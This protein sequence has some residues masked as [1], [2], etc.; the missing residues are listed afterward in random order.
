MRPDD[1]GV[2]IL[3]GGAA[4]RL[5][6][7]LEIRG[8]DG[9]PLLRAVYENVRHAGPVVVAA[10][11]SLSRGLDNALACTVVLDR[12][13]RRGPLGGLLSALPAL[14]TRLAFVVA[15]DAPFVSATVALR[16]GEVWEDGLQGVV[17]VNRLGFSEPLCAL[18]ERTAL[19]QAVSVELYGS[20]S[21]AGAAA[22]L[23]CKHVHFLDDRVFLNVNT[24]ADR[25]TVLQ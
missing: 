6:G 5:P 24:P 13:E 16:L 25:Y 12:F 15:G 3:A 23:R 2:V 7:K 11:G 10:N 17:P 9:V 14:R 4:T 18:Y 21:A 1:L 22:R 8:R 20:A 19:L